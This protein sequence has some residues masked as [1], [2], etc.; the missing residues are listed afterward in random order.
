MKVL[1]RGL[2]GSTMRA[3]LYPGGYKRSTGDMTAG[4]YM[5]KEGLYVRWPY[6]LTAVGG[7]VALR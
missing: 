6:A 2:G 1:W 7:I 5:G 4:A 3:C